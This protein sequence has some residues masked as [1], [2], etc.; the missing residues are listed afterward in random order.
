VARAL[1]KRPEVLILDDPAP[2][3]SDAE[4]ADLIRAAIAG[5]GSKRPTSLLRSS[6]PDLLGLCGTVHVFSHGHL[7]ESGTYP[8]LISN[9]SSHLS[10]L[11][12][13]PAT[14]DV[15][16]PAL[17]RTGRLDGGSG[18]HSKKTSEASS[19]DYAS[20][21]E[22]IMADLD[23]REP[24]LD[25][26]G[27]KGK[28]GSAEALLG[29]YEVPAGQSDEE[30]ALAHLQAAP[31]FTTGDVFKLSEPEAGLLTLG[32]VAAAARGMV[33]P[34]FAA[35]LA[36]LLVVYADEQPEDVRA[37]AN[38][39]CLVV[40][41]VAA[42]EGLAFYLK[43]FAFE[44]SGERLTL[45]IRK[46]T[47]DSALGHELA[48]FELPEHGPAAILKG[49]S[50][51]AARVRGATTSAWG[52]MIGYLSTVIGG[53][54][55]SMI[56]GWKLGLVA[57]AAVPATFLAS[58]L[59]VWAQGR[60]AAEA[61]AGYAKADAIAAEAI[62]CWRS[63]TAH[64]LEEKEFA[65]YTAAL[66]ATKD[67]SNKGRAWASVAY[68][69][70][71]MVL[72]LSQ[73]L[74][75]WF[76]M[77][78]LRPF[79]YDLTQIVMI[80]SLAAFCGAAAG[81]AGTFRGAFE[82]SR[83][84][85]AGIA[86]LMAPGQTHE[87]GRRYMG[88]ATP[89]QGALDVAG[90]AYSDTDSGLEVLKNIGVSVAPGEHVAVVGC[91]AEERD[92]LLSLILGLYLPNYGRIV[93]DGVDV[94]DWDGNYLRSKVVGLWDRNAPVFSGTVA[95]NVAYGLP[96][97]KPEH[98]VRAGE[99]AGLA[100]TVKSWERQWETVLGA[101]GIDVDDETG[102]RLGL[103]GFGLVGPLGLWNRR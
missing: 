26:I 74:F 70:S 82:A 32:S 84:A 94:R 81:Q 46:R 93:V 56:L 16:N 34:L 40:F 75:W 95:E 101:G 54:V 62:E 42:F 49:L 65:R 71:Q 88:D 14:P 15:A 30:L 43:V 47:F 28:D 96:D 99:D 59:E 76:A 2:S 10:Q 83:R 33:L 1:Y 7:V 37:G 78:V 4:E 57:W 100:D 80:W 35:V 85:L 29:R 67:A 52:N 103:G 5:D 92:A 27:F 73:A 72:F 24:V 68:G 31:V 97:A 9:P 89:M 102:E 13:R 18:A 41:T 11:R 90:L 87:P 6:R 12:S 53:F 44:L 55:W 77:T 22:Q 64:S 63:V 36:K 60:Y 69:V 48:W 66:A 45:R 58:R 51:D 98:I 3:L 19:S 38:F 39:W 23:A 91:S 61:R 50:V 25:P 86:L 21:A 20:I 17:R 8:S 79:E